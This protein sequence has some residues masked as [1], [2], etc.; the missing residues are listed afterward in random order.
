MTRLKRLLPALLAT[1]WLTGCGTAALSDC[2]PL[3]EYSNEFK[4]K[5]ADELEALPPN[6]ALATFTID[7]YVL[8][9][10]VRAC[11]R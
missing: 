2:P 1:I 10:M 4:R 3:V 8:R 11:R 5:L 9:N 6:S 7:S